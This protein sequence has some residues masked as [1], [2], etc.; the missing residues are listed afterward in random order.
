MFLY[1]SLV[2]TEKAK[3]GGIFQKNFKKIAFSTFSTNP[4]CK[5]VYLLKRLT[6]EKIL[7]TCYN[8]EAKNVSLFLKKY[9]FLFTYLELGCHLHPCF[10]K[11]LK[12]FFIPPPLMQ[13]NQGNYIL[14]AKISFDFY[15]LTYTQWE[16]T[17]F[18]WFLKI[19]KNFF[20]K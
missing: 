10:Q 2:R 8:W 9:F 4:R 7:F 12:K 13:K 20:I 18:K 19:F 1:P 16:S 11:I 5:F 15:S 3:I 14:F 6:T 17:F